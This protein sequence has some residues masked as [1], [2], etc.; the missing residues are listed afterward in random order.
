M[1]R[2]IATKDVPNAQCQSCRRFHS[3]LMCQSD[4]VY[5]FLLNTHFTLCRHIGISVGDE[6]FARFKTSAHVSKIFH[7][8]FFHSSLRWHPYKPSALRASHNASTEQRT[9]TL[10]RSSLCTIQIHASVSSTN[11][12]G[13]ITLWLPFDAFAFVQAIPPFFLSL[14]ISRSAMDRRNLN[15]TNP[16]LVDVKLGLLA[17][18]YW[19]ANE[20]GSAY[21]S[22]CFQPLSTLKLP[23]LFQLNKSYYVVE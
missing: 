18:W 7:K 20:R 1:S 9:D 6:Y 22:L 12:G 10:I 14:P 23:P 17:R 3:L 21:R 8:Y 4:E 5:C 11:H 19:N 2:L 15:L 13:S 16:N